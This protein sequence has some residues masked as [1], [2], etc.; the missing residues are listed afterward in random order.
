METF[1]NNNLKIELE[2]KP[3]QKIKERMHVTKVVKFED[4]MKVMKAK[5]SLKALDK[6]VLLTMI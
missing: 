2:I 4:N 1:I 3:V 5:A 6:M